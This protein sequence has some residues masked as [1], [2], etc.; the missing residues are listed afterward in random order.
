MLPYI[1]QIKFTGVNKPSQKW[2][3]LHNKI[4]KMISNE[5]R[6]RQIDDEPK[7]NIQVR[8]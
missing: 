4:T 2:T 3:I 6:K 5:L 8:Q 1:K 7:G